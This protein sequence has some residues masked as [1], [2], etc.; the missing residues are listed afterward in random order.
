MFRAALAASASPPR[1]LIA[2]QAKRRVVNGD[3]VRQVRAP[4]PEHEIM[5][6]VGTRAA[7]EGRHQQS[8]RAV[9]Q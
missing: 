2:R 6:A 8:R 7:R 1:G 9:L 5:M 4:C 3:A